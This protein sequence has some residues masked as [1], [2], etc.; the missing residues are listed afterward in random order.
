MADESSSDN[1]YMNII[2][3]ILITILFFAYGKRSQEIKGGDGD[4][5]YV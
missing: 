1:T 4:G 2:I 5:G 3:F